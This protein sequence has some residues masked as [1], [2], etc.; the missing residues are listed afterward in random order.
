[1]RMVFIA[2]L[3]LWPVAASAEDLTITGARIVDIGVYQI[4]KGEVTGNSATP[5]GEISAVDEAMLLEPGTGI[6]ARIGLEF[7]FRYVVEGLPEGAPVELDFVQTYPAPGLQSPD[8]GAPQRSVRFRRTKTIGKTEYLGYGFEQD[9]EM[10]P[11]KWT[12][13]VWQGESKLLFQTF[14]VGR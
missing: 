6:T 1:M 10:V 2:L 7:G 8:G 14:E 9:W 13:E 3:C 12:F 11:G 4:R 5:T